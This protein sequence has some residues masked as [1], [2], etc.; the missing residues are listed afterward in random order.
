MARIPTLMAD[1]P[2][3]TPTPTR[4]RAF[5][6]VELLIVVAI[7]GIVAAIAV[8]SYAG[9]L[10]QVRRSDATILLTEAAGE[11][12]RYFSEFNAYTSDLRELGYALAD[13]VPSD[14]GHYTL[15]AAVDAAD[16]SR[17]VLTAT[18]VP[19]GLQAGDTDCGRFTINHNGVKGSSG[20]GEGCW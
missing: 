16:P 8:P 18:P 7:L 14:E 13:A 12:V 6:L 2:R 19:G 5:T 9:Y 10:T 20:T 1:R 17:F 11:Q 3:P 15:S 4:A